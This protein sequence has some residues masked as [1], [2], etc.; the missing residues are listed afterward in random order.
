MQTLLYP[1]RTAR[2]T[3]KT[4]ISVVRHLIVSALALF[5]LL[6]IIVMLMRSV[7][8]P[9]DIY[10]V[11]TTIFPSKLVFSGYAEAFDEQILR[12]LLNTIIVVGVN[13]VFVP[14]TCLMCGYGFA[15]VRF[16]GRGACFSLLLSTIM[17]PG[18]AMQI[19][20]YIVYY[21]LKLTNSLWPLM[22]TA[23][24]G[25]GAMSIFFMRQYLKGIPDS[26]TEAA[27]V[28]G[29]NAFTIM[30]RIMLPL[31]RPVVVLT[32]VNVFIGQYNDYGT[33]L[34]YIWNEK[35]YTLAVGLYYKYLAP[36][37][38][39]IDANIQYAAGVLVMIPMVVLF[40]LFQKQLINGIV[41]SGMKM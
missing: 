39:A 29:A 32:A 11:P 18:I 28:D 1:R 37:A 15:K 23:F 38:Q 12:Y 19:P 8:S 25:G 7:M 31:A 5:F 33:A 3:K 21:K 17:I 6:P 30:F 41:T 2:R 35:Y 9:E 13:T 16:P 20:L 24:F 22:I 4:V 14:L 36:G 27:R 26:I 34:I 40:A 10:R